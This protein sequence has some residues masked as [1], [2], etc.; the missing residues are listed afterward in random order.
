MKKKYLAHTFAELMISLVVIAII[1][2]ILYPTISDCKKGFETEECLF[3]EFLNTLS[4]DDFFGMGDLA[5]Q[6]DEWKKDNKV[7]CRS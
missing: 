7:Y 4:S 1:T 6:Y 2:A 3:S 5:Y